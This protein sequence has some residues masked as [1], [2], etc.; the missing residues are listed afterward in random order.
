M[1]CFQVGASCSELLILE[2]NLPFAVV[3][4][5]EKDLQK[6]AVSSES[7]RISSKGELKEFHLSSTVDDFLRNFNVYFSV[8]SLTLSLFQ[9]WDRIPRLKTFK[10]LERLRFNFT[11]HENN[12]HRLLTALLEKTPFLKELS[13][14]GF[15]M[16]RILIKHERLELV[17]ATD[18]EVKGK[19]LGVEE[20]IRTVLRREEG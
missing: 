12:S 1:V 15:L 13:L 14:S 18:C 2:I 5:I 7:I 10:K 17:D 19:C 11:I 16:A 20:G 4:T 6:L 8:K 9:K 3:L